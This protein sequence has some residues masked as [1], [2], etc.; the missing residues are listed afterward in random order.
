MYVNNYLGNATTQDMRSL[1]VDNVVQVVRGDG[2]MRFDPGL[3]R[4]YIDRNGNPAVTINTG[5]TTLVKGAQ[6]P[7]REHVL[8]RDL[9][10]NYNFHLPIYNAT[11][12]RKDQWIE[13]DTKVV[14]AYRFR[15]R[16]Y[17]DIAAA[18]SYSVDGMRKTIVEYEMVTD[19]G[20]AVVDMDGLTPGRNDMAGY[21]GQGIPLPITHCDFFMSARELGASGG[22]MSTRMAGAAGRRVAETIEKT[23]IGV[24][25]GLTYGGVNTGL[26]YRNTS[27]VYGA[28]NFPDRLTKTNMTVPTGSNAATI[29]DD[30]LACLDQL[31]ARKAYGPFVIYTS[32]D[33][34]KYLDDDYTLTG[35]NVTTMTLRE[36]LKKIEGVTDVRRLDFLFGSAPLDTIGPGTDYDATLKTYRMLFVQMTG[37]TVRAIN[38]M[39]VTT[40]QWETH[41][42][43]QLNFKTMAIQVPQFFCDTYGNCG[44]LDAT[45]S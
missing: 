26:T 13:L 5:R 4:P 23:A 19:P 18:E 22:D 35:G 17:A 33:W 28:I 39:G 12:L 43:M 7:I 1:S 20:E 42:G 34:D 15:M 44:L 45:N 31:K 14:E 36:R 9:I 8:L 40:M 27:K 38:G 11:L 25:T 6:V 30:V 24:T 16:F 32:N 41:G 29:I 3:R 37:E 2:G 10:A 21:T